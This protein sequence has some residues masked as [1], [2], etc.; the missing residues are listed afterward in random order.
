[1]RFLVGLVLTSGV[2]LAQASMKIETPTVKNYCKQIEIDLVSAW[3][4]DKS[5][6]QQLLAAKDNAER[7]ELIRFSESLRARQSELAG[8]WKKLGC[9]AILYPASATKK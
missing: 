4:S 6:G 7:K 3:N 8:I 9:V 1:M 2:A 5:N